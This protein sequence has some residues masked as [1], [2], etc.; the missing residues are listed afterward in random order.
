MV[1]RMKK[2]IIEDVLNALREKGDPVSLEQCRVI[3]NRWTDREVFS[4]YLSGKS[5]EERDMN[6]Y[7]A[8]RDAAQFVHGNLEAATLVPDLYGMPREEEDSMEPDTGET[9]TLSRKDFNDL[10]RR[11]EKLERWTGLKRRAEPARLKPLPQGAD[12]ADYVN[13]NEACRLLGISKRSMRGYA[14]RGEVKAW[15]DRKFVV[16][17]RKDILKLKAQKQQ[18][19]CNG[20]TT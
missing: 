17:L 10:L 16:Y 15:Q 11:I 4:H 7:W 18:D 3:E 20:V 19:V 2:E 5:E 9:V 14:D 8:C 1:N 13:Q 6:L 12:R